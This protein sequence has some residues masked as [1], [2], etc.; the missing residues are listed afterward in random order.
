MY[1]YCIFDIFGTDKLIINIHLLSFLHVSCHSSISAYF[2]DVKWLHNSRV[3]QFSLCSSIL[4]CSENY[5][6]SAFSDFML[7]EDVILK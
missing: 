4:L 2:V 6:I 5:F 7:I 3:V 1:I